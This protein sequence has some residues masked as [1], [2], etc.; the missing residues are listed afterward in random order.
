MKKDQNFENLLNKSSNFQLRRAV[1][2]LREGLFDPFGIRLLTTSDT[3][4]NRHYKTQTGNLA[5]GKSAHLC[6]CGAYGQ[7]KSHTLNYIRQRA[8]EENY[9]VSYINLDPREVPFHNLKNVY[10]S[11]MENLTFPAPAHN[12]DTLPSS[13]EVAP[14]D[15]EATPSAKKAAKA[16]HKA[17][18]SNKDA[19]G[20]MAS[21]V[22]VS[23]HQLDNGVVDNGVVDNGSVDNDPLNNDLLQLNGNAVFVD[24]WKE[25]A[26]HWLS[27]PENHGKSVEDMIPESI[28]HRFKSI[29][30]AMALQTE[31]ISR[32]KRQLKKHARFKPREFPWILN[33][34]F[35]G[36]EIPAVQL[37]NALRYR[38]VSFYKEDTLVCKD[39]RLYLQAIQGYGTLFQNMGYK[40]LVVLFDEAESIMF[41]RI[42]QRSKSYSI[43]HEL[44]RSNRPG[45]GFLPVFAFTHD[46]FM[47]L[48]EE[49]FERTRI[50]R[51]RKKRAGAIALMT[52]QGQT[53]KSP[54]IPDEVPQEKE[55]LCFEQDFSKAWQGKKIH[56]HTLQDLT[57][58]EWHQLIKKLIQ[59]HALAYEWKPNVTAMDKKIYARLLKQSDAESRMKLK[60]IVN[61]LDLAQQEKVISALL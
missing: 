11:L 24:I 14:S 44:F 13:V 40:G 5:K 52:E 26:Q 55:V 38:Q 58:R 16:Q 53:K 6:V 59:M 42:T 21:R 57:S 43:L 31:S 32:K 35:L 4:L 27:L 8:L 36:K 33:N 12:T 3:A 23:A 60:L 28:P 51:K 34:A 20:K 25:K 29:I 1:E 9:A 41:T 37:R 54:E 47:R 50:I 61:L 22:A 48:K 49:D 15:T 56:I 46:F 39:D 7:G 30:T 45:K 2:R 19:S 17:P 18:L 10:R